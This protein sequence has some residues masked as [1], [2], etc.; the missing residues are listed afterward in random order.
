MGVRVLLA[1]FLLCGPSLAFAQTQTRLTVRVEHSGDDSVGS[2]V[3][4]ALREELRRSAGYRLSAGYGLSIEDVE[5]FTVSLV[6]LDTAGEG[7]RKGNESAMAVAY[8]MF[9]RLPLELGNPQTWL[10]IFL[11]HSVHT[12]GSKRADEVGKD[13]LAALDRQVERYKAAIKSQ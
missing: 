2:S 13:L 6:T 11:S 10:P 5:S 7:G 4:F 3:A 8:T 9:N 1:V 12:V